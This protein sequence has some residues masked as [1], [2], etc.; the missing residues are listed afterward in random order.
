MKKK[1]VIAIVG[2]TAVGKTALGIYL[3]NQL[4]GEIISGDSLQVYKQLDIGTAKATKEEQAQATHHLIDVREINQ[5]YSVADFQKEGRKLIKQ[6]DV[7]IIVGGTGLYVQSLLEDYSLGGATESTGIRE[8]Y[9]NYLEENGKAALWQLLKETDPIAADIIHENNS[10]KIIRALEVFENTGKSIIN[11]DGENTLE[12]Y[13]TKIIGLITDRELLYERIN[14]RI[15]LMMN[16]GLLDEAKLLFE[17]YPNAQAAQGIGYKEFF[18]YFR[19]E[20]TLTECVE[21]VKKNSRNYAKR[22]ITWFRNRMNTHWI[23]IVQNPVAIE[24]ELRELTLWLN[25]GG[26]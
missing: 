21:L 20:T 16:S 18:P 6:I 2:P 4:G 11:A 5:N 10:R 12:L 24:Q 14:Q 25:D 15:D 23:D 26:N 7:P 19:G 1:K 3:A 9:Q 8:K 22:Q 17:K 13:D